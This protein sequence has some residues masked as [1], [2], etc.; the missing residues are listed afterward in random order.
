MRGER[1]QNSWVRKMSSHT[2]PSPDRKVAGC[3]LGGI[4]RVC[5]LTP[6]LAECDLRDKVFTEVIKVIREGTDLL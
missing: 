1:R 6:H 3:D 5:V 4:S 2:Q